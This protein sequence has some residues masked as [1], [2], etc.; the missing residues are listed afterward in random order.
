[1][2]GE[3]GMAISQQHPVSL[4]PSFTLISPLGPWLE[5]RISGT[6][7]CTY[8]L[9]R[10][11]LLT[12]A[13]MCCMLA[14]L[15][16]WPGKSVLFS[17]QISLHHL[18]QSL[19]RADTSWPFWNTFRSRASQVGSLSHNTTLPPPIVHLL[20]LR[21]SLCMTTFPPGTFTKATYL[22]QTENGWNSCS[23]ICL[24]CNPLNIEVGGKLTS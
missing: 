23:E 20:R 12:N 13:L 21:T 10:L 7:D 16:V 6:A 2:T 17:S 1:M 4:M 22:A 8:Y 14:L 5:L 19:M 3:V 18:L 11:R 24:L 9:Q 15:F